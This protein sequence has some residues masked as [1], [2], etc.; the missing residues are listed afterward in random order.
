MKS[1][2]MISRELHP[3]HTLGGTAYAIRRLADQ[4]TE[5]EIKTRVLFTGLCGDLPREGLV[6][7]ANT[8]ALENAS[9]TASCF[10]SAAM[11]RVFSSCACSGRRD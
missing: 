1:V 5:L 6:A 4:L 8:D 9:R 10:A 11:Q 2:T 7:F 3:F